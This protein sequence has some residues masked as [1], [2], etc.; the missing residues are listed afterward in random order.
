M[1]MICFFS[2]LFSTTRNGSSFSTL[3]IL[4][5]LSF[6]VLMLGCDG[7]SSA[8]APEKKPITTTTDDSNQSASVDVKQ[9]NSDNNIKSNSATDTVDITGGESLITAAKPDRKSATGSLNNS[10]Q[11]SSNK[12][13]ATL[14]GD[15]MGIMP[16]S[17]CDSTQVLVNLFA[18]GSVV[19]TSTYN[20]PQKPTA[21]LTENG[22]YRQDSDIITI[23]Y[24]DQR[25]ESYLI[26][27]SH[28]VLLN[29]DKVADTDYTLSRK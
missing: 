1:L 9:D 27:N 24:D 25:I 28:L 21:S 15:Y 29:D 2:K 19:K 23:V 26:Q 7:H 3:K 13:Q 8:P 4:L 20:N 14:I 10:E 5:P 22:I 11:A 6:A 12:M 18:D 17:F 16:C